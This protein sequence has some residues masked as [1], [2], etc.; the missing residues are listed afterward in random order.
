[1]DKEA[2]R[3]E[4]FNLPVE[5]PECQVCLSNRHSAIHTG[6]EI[7]HDWLKEEQVLVGLNS[8]VEPASNGKSSPASRIIVEQPH[9]P[10][11]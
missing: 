1:L 3:T 2:F 10:V 6:Y 7:W 11:S 9:E 8:P 5:L 4:I